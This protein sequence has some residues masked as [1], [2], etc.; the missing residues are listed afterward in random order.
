MRTHGILVLALVS[1]G[2]LS[3]ARGMVAGEPGFSGQAERRLD[4][5]EHVLDQNGDR[6]APAERSYIESRLVASRLDLLELG[7]LSPAERV[8][9]EARIEARLRELNRSAPQLGRAMAE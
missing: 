8:E 9:F 2:W 4:R 3:S 5:W 6:L 1:F 7:S